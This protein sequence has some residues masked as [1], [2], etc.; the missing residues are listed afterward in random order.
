VPHC[1]SRPASRNLFRPGSF[2]LE[3]FLLDVTVISIE[4]TNK[5]VELLLLLSKGILTSEDVCLASS[6]IF[7]LLDGGLIVPLPS[8]FHGDVATKQTISNASSALELAPI[9]SW[10]ESPSSRSRMDVGLR[11]DDSH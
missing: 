1:C 3:A 9:E 2:G 4:L 8:S 7:C 10:L 5:S 6:L 11:S